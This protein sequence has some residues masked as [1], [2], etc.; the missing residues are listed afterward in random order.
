MSSIELDT[1]ILKRPLAEANKLITVWRKCG[2]DQPICP[3]LLI[4]ELVNAR[5]QPDRLTIEPNNLPDKVDG[6]MAPIQDNHWA[7]IIN[8]KIK[9]SGRRRF[10]LAHEMFHFIA[11]RKIRDSFECGR[12]DINSFGGESLEDDANA[13][14]AQLLIPSDVLRELDKSEFCYD[15][16]KDNADA[17]DVSVTALAYKWVIESRKRIGFIQSRDG[18]VDKGRASTPAYR[19]GI[20]FKCGS[21][22][23]AAS[24]TQFVHSGGSPQKQVLAPNTWHN[25]LGCSECV[26]QT[27]FEG[28]TYTF[29]DFG[30]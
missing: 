7:A 5:E 9:S 1:A 12:A 8:Q 22:L 2:P 28:Y 3:T 15:V 29:L 18:F 23:P 30:S 19:E 14:A 13:F 20:F 4:N 25:Y 26:H 11:H 24:L 10:T 17:L 27:S 16:V 21:E 6:M